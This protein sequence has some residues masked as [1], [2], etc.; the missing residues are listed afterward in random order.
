[1]GKLHTI[2]RYILRDPERFIDGYWSDGTKRFKGVRYDKGKTSTVNRFTYSY[3]SF[4]K[5]ILAGV[6]MSDDRERN[7]DGT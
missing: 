6:G 5:H 7:S 2:R 4:V 3:R 1:M